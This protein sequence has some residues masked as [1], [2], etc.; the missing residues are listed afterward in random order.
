[1]RVDGVF[2]PFR[3]MNAYLLGLGYEIESN[4]FGNIKAEFFYASLLQGMPDEVKTDTASS[5]TKMVGY[6]GKDVGYELDVTYSYLFDRGL[7]LGANLAAAL[8][9]DAWKIKEQNQKIITW[10][11]ATSQLTSNY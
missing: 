10:F 4:K 1:M 6:Y 11:K 5:E 8:P 2:D 9:G 3:I 7:E